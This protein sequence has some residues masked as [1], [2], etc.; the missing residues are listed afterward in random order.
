M[1]GG[2]SRDANESAVVKELHRQQ[3]EDREEK[4]RQRELKMQAVSRVFPLTS[5]LLPYVSSS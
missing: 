4:L 5:C 1:G 2:A 3:R